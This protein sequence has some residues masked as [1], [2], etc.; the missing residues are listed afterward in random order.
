MA[1]VC[2]LTVSKVIQ[3]RNES[4]CGFIRYL[5]EVLMIYQVFSDLF[6]CLYFWR[7]SV[8][9][10]ATLLLALAPYFIYLC[11]TLYE[12]NMLVIIKEYIAV[13]E[14]DIEYYYNTPDLGQ[15]LFSPGYFR[16]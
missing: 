13:W 6:I 11:F 14:A 10:H 3:R 12:Y 4:L 1:I 16:N 2:C 8:K 15:N 9:T 7:S 5:G